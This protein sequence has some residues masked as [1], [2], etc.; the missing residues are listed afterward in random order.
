MEE[1]GEEYESEVEDEEDVRV[2]TSL[3]LEE[4]QSKSCVGVG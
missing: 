1:G 4:M 2:N 3:S